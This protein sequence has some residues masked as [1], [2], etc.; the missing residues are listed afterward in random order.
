MGRG[1]PVNS[2]MGQGDFKV[3]FPGQ[4][5]KRG[6][7]HAQAVGLVALAVPLGSFRYFPNTHTAAA[8]MCTQTHTP[9]M[10]VFS[11]LRASHCVFVGF[12]SADCYIES[13]FSLIV[14][15]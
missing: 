14:T 11:G 15:K 9:V 10:M 1:H 12:D 5:A 7:P 3:S 2:H 6:S 8:C 4:L 13:R